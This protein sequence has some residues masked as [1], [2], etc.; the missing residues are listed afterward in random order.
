MSLSNDWFV[1]RVPFR[2]IWA[3]TKPYYE[4]HIF[5]RFPIFHKNDLRIQG[6]ILSISENN[7]EIRVRSER[8]EFYPIIEYLTVLKELN[9]YEDVVRKDLLRLNKLPP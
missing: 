9:C 5:L 1:I 2:S 7:F 3:P 4:Q 6:N 8:R